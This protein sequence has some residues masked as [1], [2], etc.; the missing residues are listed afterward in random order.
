MMTL[1]NLLAIALMPTS[2]CVYAQTAENDT[3]QKPDQ[4]D[5]NIFL[6]AASDSKPREISLGLPTNSLSAVQIFEDGLPVS[7]Y[8]YELLPYKSWHGGVSAARTGSIGP[9]ETAM[10]YGEINNFVDSYNRGGSKDFQGS[11]QYTY[12]TYG[13]HKIDLN[14]SGPLG[15]GWGYSLSTY[16]NF[17][18]GSNHNVTPVLQNRHQFYKG[19]LSHNFL[20]GKG[21]MAFTYQYVDYLTYRENYGPFV[22]VG[23]GSVKEMEGFR[24]GQDSYRP[25]ISSFKFLDFMTGQMRTMTF[26][27]GNTDKTHHAT[28]TLDYDL[29]HG[30]HL[31]VR[32]RFKTGDYLGGAGS[33]MGIKK[34]GADN[35][36]T[37]LDGSA[38]TGNVQDRNILHFD[39]F[40]T[41]WMNNAELQ[42]TR[43]NHSLRTGFDYHFNHGGTVNSSVNFAHEAKANPNLLLFN[44]QTF[45]NYNTGGEY[46]DGYEHK[47]AAY[48]KDEWQIN[49]GTNLTAFVRAEF[50]GI[51]GTA[52][53]NLNGETV[54]NRYPGFNLTLGKTNTFKQNY[55]NGSFGLDFNSKLVGG[56]SA[57]AQAIFTRVHNTI[58]DY[59]GFYDPNTNPT[60]T[61]F[62]QGGFAY[63]GKGFNIVS[64]LVYIS[65]SNYNTRS[66]FQH[67]LQKE[68]AGYPIGFVESVTMPVTYGIESLGW[69]TDAIFTPFQGFNLHMQ[70]TI[71]DPKYKDFRFTPT[72]SDGVTE[73]YDFSDKNVT[74]LHKVEVSVDP[75][76]TYKD[77]RFWLSARYI[78]KQY[79][80]KT[81]SLFF[82]ERIETFG[83]VDYSLNNKCKLSVNIINLLNQKGASGLISSADLVEDAS[84]YKNYLMSGTFIR[85]FTI[86]LGVKIDF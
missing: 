12:G 17:D 7:Y 64:Q 61:K 33:L 11:I 67:A 6:N 40:E 45:Y 36:Y 21:K 58:F 78:S 76:Y 68:I 52:A 72:F 27:E 53:N 13:Q 48:V 75:S 26:D 79:I 62:A 85:P 84:G 41:S 83:G 43:G 29:G 65:Q 66:Q 44:G 77:W 42:F 35:G 3:I 46:Y 28:F 34:V 69:T 57:K 82:K 9:M 49:R 10:R 20:N 8:I 80:N 5:S 39:S 60:D 74:N 32:S 50:L 31:D 56:L 51:H 81:N 37:L 70:F 30:T 47:A 86:E 38:Y 22:F 2:L 19:V 14:I 24:L 63:T 55:L 15:K 71:R 23:D 73:E 16:Q 54:N 1:K 25:E 59:G 4:Q 18:P